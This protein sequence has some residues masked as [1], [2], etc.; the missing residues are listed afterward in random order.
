M[1]LAAIL[2]SLFRTVF[3]E[4]PKIRKFS[5]QDS[6]VEGDVVSVTCFAMTKIKPITFQWLKNDRELDESQDNIKFDT[7]SQISALI[8]DPVKLTDSANYTCATSNADGSDRYTASLKVKASPKWLEQPNNIVTVMGSSIEAR[9]SA[10]G[11]PEPQI[12]WKKKQETPSAPMKFHHQWSSG[13]NSSSLKISSVTYDHADVYECTADN[14]IPPS[15]RAN[16]TLNVRDPPKV[17]QFRFDDTIKEGDVASVMC[18]VTSGSKPVTF[19]WEKNGKPISI[20]SNDVRIDDGAIHSVLV[21]DSVKLS[22]DGNYT[23]KAIN[24]EGQDSFTA[25]LNV[26]ASPKWK[27]EPKSLVVQV[28]APVK[29][30][31]IASGSPRPNIKWRKIST[32]DGNEFSDVAASAGNGLDFSSGTFSLPSV[33]QSDSG[34]YECIASNGIKPSIK[35]NFSIV[36]RDIPKIQ[37][38]SFP[39]NV[40]EGNM[41]SVTCIAATKTKPISFEWLKNSKEIIESDKNIRIT[42]ANDVSVLIVD[43]VTLEHSGNYTCSATNSVGKDTFTAAL[44]VKASPKWLEQPNDIVTTVGSTVVVRCLAS[45]SPEPTIQWT[46]KDGSKIAD[47]NQ[48]LSKDAKNSSILRIPHVSY[49]DAGQYECIVDN[50]I[51]PVI[52]NVPEIQK[53]SFQDDIVEGKRVSVTCLVSSNSKAVSFSWHKNGK[54]ISSSEPNLKI[55]NDNEFSVLILDP[56]N[57]HDTANYTCKATN[58]HGSDQHSAYLIV[59]APPKWLETPKDIITTIA[60]SIVITCDASGSPKPRIH[61]KKLLDKRNVSLLTTLKEQTSNE[62]TN[63][64]KISPVTHEDAGFYECIAENGISNKIRSNFSITVRDMPVI[65]KFQFKENVKE[66]DF[67][68]VVCLVKSGTQPITFIWY[69]NGNQLKMLNKGVSLENSPV[70]SALILNSVTSEDDGNYTCT[71]KNSFGSDHHSAVLKIRAPPKWIAKPTD[72][73]VVMGEAVSTNCI[74]SGSPIPNIRWRKIADSNIHSLYNLSSAF[75]NSNDSTLKFPRVSYENAGTYE[76]TADNGIMPSIETNFTI[77]IRESP[78][79][80]SFQFEENV[81]EGDFVSVVCLV[82]SGAQPI[83]FAWYKNGEEFKTSNKDVSIENTSVTSALILKSV[84]SKSDGNYTCSAKNSFGSDRHS[85]SLKIKAAP[86]WIQQPADVIIVMGDA[87]SVDCLASGS[88]PP[89]ISWKRYSDV[90]IP[91]IPINLNSSLST[92]NGSVLRIPKISYEDAGIYECSADNG[93]P[94]AIKTNFSITIRDVP[95]IK[96]FTFEDNVQEGDLASVTCIAIS[97]HKP[98]LFTWSR[99]GQA[100]DQT[101]SD[102]RIDNSGEYSILILDNVSLKSA[103]NYTCTVSSP[104]NSASHTA[105]LV[106]K[107]HPKWVEKPS[108]LITT[109]GNAVNVRCSASGSPRPTLRWIKLSGA[110]FSEYKTFETKGSEFRNISESHLKIPTVSYKDAGDYECIADNGM[111]PSIQTN[112][113]IVIRVSPKWIKTPEDIVTSIG[114]SVVLP[115]LA[116]GS[117][118]PRIAWKKISGAERKLTTLKSSQYDFEDNESTLKIKS[119]SYEDSVKIEPFNFLRRFSVGEKAQATCFVVSDSDDIQFHWFKDKLPLKE[120]ENV[121]L[122]SSNDFSVII[123]DH[124]DL[125]SEGNY[126]CKATDGKKYAEHSAQL[127]VQAAPTWLDETKDLVVAMGSTIIIPC[128]AHGSPRPQVKLRKTSGHF[129]VTSNNGTFVVESVTADHSGMYLCE[130]SNSVG[131]VISKNFSIAVEDLPKVQPFHFPATVKVGSRITVVCSVESASEILTFQWLKDKEQITGTSEVRIKNDADFSVLV[132][133]P[134]HSNS[135]GNYTCS[136]RNS[137]GEDNYSTFL[138]VEGPPKWIQKPSDV[139]IHIGETLVLKCEASGFPKPQIS[140]FKIKEFSSSDEVTVIDRNIWNDTLL[141]VSDIDT[142]YSGLYLCEADNKILPKLKAKAHVRVIDLPKVQPFN[143]K[144]G[145]RIGD[146]T[147][148]L[149]LAES[150]SPLSYVW[151]KDGDLLSEKDEIRFKTDDELSILIIE[152]VKI[153]NSGNY[154]CIAKNKYGSDSFTA[155]L[156]VEAPPVWLTEPENITAVPGTRHVFRCSATGSPKPKIT[157][158]KLSDNTENDMTNTIGSGETLTFESLKSTDG[159]TYECEARNGVEPTLKKFVMLGIRDA[160]KIPPLSFPPN[161]QTGLS[162]KVLCTVDRGIKPLEFKWKFNGKDIYNEDSAVL[163]NTYDDFSVLNVDPVSSKYSGNYTCTVTNSH[164]KDSFTTTLMV[165]EP[166]SWIKEP[167]D[168][169]VLEGEYVSIDCMASGLPKPKIQWYKYNNLDGPLSNANISIVVA[170]NGTLTIQKADIKDV[171]NYECLAEN[172]LGSPLRKLITLKVFGKANSW[173]VPARFEEK[174]AVVN[175]K[176]G[177]SARMKCEALGDQPLAVTWQRDETTI[178]KSG[179]ERYEIFET[180]VPK[181]VMSELIIRTTDRDDGALYSCVAEN[182]FGNDQ[183]KI[184]LL[185]MEVPAPPLDVKIR[186]IWSRSASV[187]WAPPYSGNSPITKYIVQYW[188]DIGGAPHRLLEISAPSSQSSALLKD[189]HPGTPYVLKVVAE[190]A[191]GRGEPSDGAFFRTGEEEPSSPPADINAEPRGSSTIRV[192]WKP[193]PKDSWNGEL[194]GYYVGYKSRDSNQPYSYKSM[195][196]LPE[197]QQEFFLT[198]LLK[199]SDYSVVVKAYNS[200]GSGPPSHELYVRTLDGDLP[201]APSLYVLAT[202]PTS[203]SL[204]WNT[205]K[206][207][208]PLSGYTVHYREEQGQWQEVAVV[209]PEDNTYTLSNLQPQKLYQIYVTATNQYGKGDPSEIVAIKTDEGDGHSMLSVAGLGQNTNYLDMAI[210]IPVTASLLTIGV[211]LV[212]ACVCVKKIRSRHNL[213]RAMAAEKHLAMVGTLQRYVD[214]DKTRSLMD[215]SR[216]GHYPLPYET[217]QMLADDQDVSYPKGG[218]NQELR[219]FATKD[220]QPAQYNKVLTLRKGTEENIYDSPQ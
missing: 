179:D 98:L 123:I 178:S 104:I 49:E 46:K 148:G 110:N 168:K 43:P 58:V 131:S 34:F 19:Q 74:A 62:S 214:I 13:R 111:S 117:P 72:I 140:W 75:V 93:I 3:S 35:S 220:G 125:S 14:G 166:T 196:Y 194:K 143:F 118:K 70:I 55:R 47:S 144:Q 112:F 134:V 162:T 85:T 181:G 76:C 195:E 17:K 92:N 28:G 36:I 120:S 40:I 78:V 191:V 73:I 107:A 182:E 213:E 173:L 61:W 119:L 146:K 82:K 41:V 174:F 109:I 89:S 103:G 138:Q 135:T 164:G 216:M 215:A 83:I 79:I 205:R 209:A 29:V 5:F 183:R 172:G 184:R 122:K 77:T 50:G 87:V 99:N 156:L 66:D 141:M 132:I 198:N 116:T 101:T 217:I 150:K 133:E 95:K 81:K 8:I 165:Q 38:F 37:T 180:L 4:V 86:K 207:D 60:E 192:S 154:T 106:V 137:L 39:E 193:P 211:V 129:E 11:S 130:A 42:S 170:N 147:S 208:N 7:G 69:K 113:S 187:T 32:A 167:D 54:D 115:C 153:E 84:S 24:A 128:R 1:F 203:V 171:G 65:E 48:G 31:C 10:S 157:W 67:V 189:L 151:R 52:S 71:A 45:G 20:A 175:A 152:P 136:V 197:V 94:P 100:I 202:S 206:I 218:P 149:C 105:E 139:S 190:N 102:V 21:F 91:L 124:V 30:N 188:R 185:V 155:E 33:S 9:C 53:F 88:P 108:S 26:K 219:A 64:L 63:R 121:R 114:D 56:V 68:S 25:E 145:A 126:T 23:C 158:R 161:V 16:F 96:K 15:I 51:P 57:L 199:A 212:V 201:P 210:V 90:G 200:A 18:L 177:D 176:K 80:K 12:T 163:I 169:E 27:E 142:E 97:S 160:P 2:Q 159:G 127:Q 44:R 186:E 6:I 204:R 22:D 59:K